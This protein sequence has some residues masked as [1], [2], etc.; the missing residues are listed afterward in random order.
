MHYFIKNVCSLY[1]NFLEYMIYVELNHIDKN[2]EQL[3]MFLKQING[4]C[5]AINDKSSCLWSISRCYT[6]SSITIRLFDVALTNSDINDIK[7][8]QHKINFIHIT[9]RPDHVFN[10]ININNIWYYISSWM[11]LYSGVMIKIDNLNNFLDCIQLYFIDK[12]YKKHRSA[13]D[14]FMKFIE[15]YFIFKLHNNGGNMIKINNFSL[16]NQLIYRTG[17]NM[18]ENMINLIKIKKS[19]I[20]KKKHYEFKILYGHS[21]I[22]ATKNTSLLLNKF[23]EQYVENNTELFLNAN[24]N[25]NEKQFYDEYSYL[26]KNKDII[27]SKFNYYFD[28]VIGKSKYV[29]KIIYL[30]LN[31]SL[32]GGYHSVKYNYNNDMVFG[33]N[34]YILN[35]IFMGNIINLHKPGFNMSNDKNCNMMFILKYYKLLQYYGCQNI[36]IN[37]C[38]NLFKHYNKHTTYRITKQFCNIVKNNEIIGKLCLIKIYDDEYLYEFILFELNGIHIMMSEL[39]SKN[40]NDYLEYIYFFV[41]YNNMIF[42]EKLNDISLELFNGNIVN[43][44]NYCGFLQQCKKYYLDILQNNNIYDASDALLFFCKQ[45]KTNNDLL[46]FKTNKLDHEL[47]TGVIFCLINLL[48]N[49]NI[50]GDDEMNYMID[51]SK[52]IYSDD[53]NFY[54]SIYLKLSKKNHVI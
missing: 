51:I 41:N 38:T 11:L 35:Q 24:N 26:I 18:I 21:E 49:E 1:S 45:L 31:Y 30:L 8:R 50:N 43:N 33:S 9:I 36:F 54:K 47:T 46:K 48:F 25:V 44:F 34:S 7:S 16:I 37:L 17:E 13:D 40:I 52:I 20:I 23:F 14:K 29:N 3:N 15:T 42:I 10:L 4:N 28:N 22:L 2:K 12:N 39:N 53:Y 5:D 19:E 27:K 6:F 32:Q